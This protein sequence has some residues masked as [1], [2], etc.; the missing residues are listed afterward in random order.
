MNIFVCV[1]Q[2][3]DTETK[4]VPNSDNSFVN[5]DNIKWIMNP[6]D[7]F[8]V[9][10]AL[11]VKQSNPS[12]NI[13]VVRI[14]SKQS[15]EALRTAMAMGADQG[16]LVNTDENL[17]AFSTATALKG[18][19]E[20]SGKTPDLIFCGK[21]AIDSDSLQVPQLLAQLLN[22]P[23]VSVV[24]NYEQNDS[25]LKLQREVDGGSL[26][27]Y[28]VNSPCLVACNKGLNTPR[29]AS[30]PGI[31]K[32]KK[33]PLDEF[34]LSEVGVSNDSK[35]VEYSNFRLPA[36]KPAGKVFDASEE[37]NQQDVVS[38]VINLLRTEAKVL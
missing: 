32:A 17:D 26:E 31:M 28:E 7:E 25:K 15:S 19:I 23:S 24:V 1:K 10:Q 37:A 21:Q 18:A 22:L 30:L 34:N 8:A 33:K 35:K 29:Y 2:V 13:T 4:I 9:E 20:K 27:V 5:L 12:A 38:N 11:L 36:E 16:I 3:P 14:G 6:Y